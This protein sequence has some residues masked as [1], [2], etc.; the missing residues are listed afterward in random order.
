MLGRF[1]QAD[2]IVPNPGNPQDLNRYTY[3]LNNPLK[4]TDPTGHWVH[5]AV[6]AVG[7]LIGG[8]AYGYGSQVV[9]NL[10]QGMSLGDALTTDID[11]AKVAVYAGAGA[12]IGGTM[13]AAVEVGVAAVTAYGAKAAGAAAA[14]CA[15][16]DCTS[17]IAAVWSSDP[18]TRGRQIHEMLGENLA[19]NF[20][21]IDR[22][23]NGVATSIKTLDLTAKSYQNIGT[24]T[25]KVQGYID[26]LA[27]FQG[28]YRIS[29][30]MIKA[31]D[32]LLAV[33]TGVGTEA[34]WAALRELQELAAQVGVVLNIVQVP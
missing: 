22:F 13:G 6:G 1:I 30:N 7:G 19:P 24:L 23:A 34:Q 32:L 10:N 15:D 33:Q 28:A 18:W 31:R 11:P 4:Y 29:S 16:G 3:G 5:L 2:T 12:P 26:T 20:P 25:A 27:N 21:T 17:E 8:A 9:A 14:A